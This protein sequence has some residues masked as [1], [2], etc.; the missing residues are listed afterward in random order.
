MT[1]GGEQADEGRI[2]ARPPPAVP[3]EVAWLED[4]GLRDVGDAHGAVLMRA[5]RA[6]D[7]T[8]NPQRKPHESHHRPRIGSR[9]NRDFEVR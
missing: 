7:V 8:V 5:L 2:R 1:Q 9:A 4:I 6:G 3:V